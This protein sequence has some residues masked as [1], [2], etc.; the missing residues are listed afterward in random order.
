MHQQRESLPII[1]R[2]KKLET[3]SSSADINSSSPSSGRVWAA[4]SKVLEKISNLSQA[5]KDS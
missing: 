4:S 2:K 5:A 3:N 1:D